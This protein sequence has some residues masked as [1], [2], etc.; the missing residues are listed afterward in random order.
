MKQGTSRQHINNSVKNAKQFDSLVE[1]RPSTRLRKRISNPVK[2]SESNLKYKKQSRKKKVKNSSAGKALGDYN[3]AKI[4]DEEAEYQC[5]FEGCNMTFGSK[6]ELLQ[7][8]RNIC[9][10]KGCGK[11]F[12]SHKYLVQ[13]WR[14]HLDDRPLKC[15][16]RVVRWHS[17]GHGHVLN[18]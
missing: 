17:N 14:V 2:Q 3:N 4:K 5:D 18:T 8:K 10:V 16:G 6:S 7:H 15:R 9:P 12:F 11:K 1:D 13:H